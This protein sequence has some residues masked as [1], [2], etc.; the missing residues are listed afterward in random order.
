MQKSNKFS[1]NL[2]SNS[3]KILLFERFFPFFCVF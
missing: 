3:V 2:S 1:V